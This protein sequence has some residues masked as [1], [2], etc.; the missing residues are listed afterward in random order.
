MG[1]EGWGCFNVVT[2]RRDAIY[3]K[4]C[5]KIAEIDGRIDKFTTHKLLNP[6]LEKSAKKLY[7]SR[8]FFAITWVHRDMIRLLSKS[9]QY[10]GKKDDKELADVLRFTYPSRKSQM[11]PDGRVRTF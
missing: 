8:Q 2:S 10:D 1:A 11:L 4:D 3:K 5:P 7:V 6:E 9:C